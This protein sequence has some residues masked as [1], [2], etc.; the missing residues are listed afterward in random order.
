[1]KNYLLLIGIDKYQSQSTLSNCVKDVK[2]FRDVL[3]NQYHFEEEHTFELFDSSASNYNIQEVFKSIASKVESRDN[4]V[5]F[6]S[7]HGHYDS[8]SKRGF[9]IPVDGKNDYTTW[10]GNDTI[11]TLLSQIS[12]K[13]LFLIV[14]SC[15]SHSLL[16]SEESSKSIDEYG[17]RNSRWALVSA[18]DESWAPK[19]PLLN[20]DFAKYIIE[21][22]ETAE[23]EFRIGKLIDHVKDSFAD[24]ELQ[25]PQGHPLRMKGHKGG[26]FIFSIQNDLDKRDFK[27]YS[28]FHNVLRLYKR[29]AAFTEIGKYEEKSLKI[30]YQLFQEIDPVIK[31]LTHYLYLY[32]GINLTQTV[33]HLFTTHQ[34]VIEKQSLVILLQKEKG[35]TDPSRRLANVQRLFSPINTFYID[36]FIRNSCTPKTDITNSTEDFLQIA[37]FII[38]SYS[39]T[40]DVT[41]IEKYI[42]IWRNKESEPIIILKG[43]GGIGKTTFAHYLMDRFLQLSPETIPLF[44]DSLLIK[45]NLLKRANHVTK[46]S[47]YNFYE[48]L[49]NDNQL[50]GEKLSEELFYLNLDAGNFLVVIDGLDEVISKVPGFDVEAFLK[51]IEDS[52]KDLGSGKV[53]ITCR[54]HFWNNA[55]TDF[56]FDVID[57]KPFDRNQAVQFF[58]KSLD[59]TSKQKKAMK[60]ADEFRFEEG[61]ELFHPYVLDIIQSVI[62]LSGEDLEL[63]L[64]DFASSK[65]NPK[66]NNDYILYRVCDREMKRVGQIRVDEQIQFFCYL[67]NDK[68]GNI[69]T[70]NLKSEMRN[71]LHRHIDEVNLEAF[72]SHPFL[73]SSPS[74]I[75]FRYDF[76]IEVFRAVEIAEFFNFKETSKPSIGRNLIEIIAESCWYDSGLNIEVSKRIRRWEEDDHLM[77]SE[78]IEQINQNT[79]ISEELKN[80][81]SG[82][83]LNIALR[84]N[85][86]FKP[87]DNE[88]NTRLIR[89]LFERSPN[90]LDNLALVNLNSE[91]KIKFDFSGI[92]VE[93]SIIDGYSFFYNCGFDSETQFIQ[94]K[95]LNLSNDYGNEK[96]NKDIFINCTYDK[97]VEQVIKYSE[98]SLKENIDRAKAFL[99]AYFHLYFSNGKLG[100]QW[101]DKVIKVRFNGIDK[102]NYGYKKVLRVL[103]G[104]E[105]IQ[106]SEEKEG[107]K[108]FV[109]DKFKNDVVRFVK[110]GTHSLIIS[111]AIQLLKN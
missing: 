89:T 102:Y 78:I 20:S 13:H 46:L 35:Q 51:S 101:E 30:G 34:K 45:D 59:K 49:F 105:L 6:Y 107:S 110:D 86:R 81:A 37:H 15:F 38:P 72:K 97:N 64:T 85:H 103:K 23:K 94:C 66:V 53:I 48:A 61:D 70:R 92:V 60:M 100:R 87:N 22:L 26:E 96:I 77:V 52:S 8:G 2:D 11:I 62:S 83:I 33:K 27:G 68:R 12:C 19:D 63:D 18:F 39:S 91:V 1:M 17:E 104:I 41:D 55:I 40:N 75:R 31:K 5:V 56:K 21:Y 3:Y 25:S 71:A 36:D 73:I 4:L 32:S 10:I 47:V 16:I 90:K 42:D 50:E 67:S 69:K 54:T 108:L 9:W 44:I 111:K 84:I 24:N 76:F 29:N 106:Q 109:N 95:L 88:S 28:R 57:L 58:E 14:D 93:N 80:R 7:G 74:Q 79:I 82:N 99:N 98:E 43:T 65:L